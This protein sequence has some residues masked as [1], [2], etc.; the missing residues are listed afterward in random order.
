MYYT[1]RKPKSKNGGSLG[2]RLSDIL[3]QGLICLFVYVADD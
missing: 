3:L 2:M 1:E